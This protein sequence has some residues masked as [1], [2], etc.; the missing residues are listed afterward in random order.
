[1]IESSSPLPKRATPPAFLRGFNVED[2]ILYVFSLLTLV[3]WRIHPFR[4]AIFSR[5]KMCIYLTGSGGKFWIARKR[6]RLRPQQRVDCRQSRPSV[7]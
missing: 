1:M 5:Q 7:D 4:P 2:L 6:A 3:I